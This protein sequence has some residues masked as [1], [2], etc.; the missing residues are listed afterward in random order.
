MKLGFRI[1]IGF[2]WLRKCPV[3]DFTY[4]SNQ[5]LATMNDRQGQL[6]A[7]KGLF[8]TKQRLGTFVETE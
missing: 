6:A 5:P 8:F 3:V 1:C 7:I 2:I 4:C